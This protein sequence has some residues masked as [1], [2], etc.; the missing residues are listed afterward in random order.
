[1]AATRRRLVR[2]LVAALLLGTVFLV[3][4]QNRSAGSSTHQIFRLRAGSGFS[5]SGSVTG[6]TPGSSSTLILTLTNP[7]AFDLSVT[8]VS[9]AIDPT[10]TQPSTCSSSNLDLSQAQY[11]DAAH[12]IVVPAHTSAGDG[13]VDLS[14]SVK[15]VNVDSDQFGCQNKKFYL[16]YTGSAQY[17]EV[18]STSVGITTSG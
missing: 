10:K 7:V 8:Q 4:Q 13:S 17:S 5:V 6:L 15:L 16:R 1:M 9:V 11:S 2:W 14:L 12:P 3:V 18:I